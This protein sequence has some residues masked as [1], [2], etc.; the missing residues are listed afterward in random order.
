M[1]HEQ[2][3]LSDIKVDETNKKKGWHYWACLHTSADVETCEDM[4][5]V[6]KFYV[7]VFKADS[8]T[9]SG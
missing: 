4:S 8:E 2:K 3:E 5:A 6:G 7:Q 9:S 1:K